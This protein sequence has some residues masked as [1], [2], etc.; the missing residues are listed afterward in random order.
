MMPEGS[1]EIVLVHIRCGSVLHT[2]GWIAEFLAHRGHCDQE[3]ALVTC[4]AC[5]RVD[6]EEAFKI[7]LSGRMELS[8]AGRWRL[9]LAEGDGDTALDNGS[10]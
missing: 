7:R 1:D 10:F 5:G 9:A 8:S 2:R 4:G 3:E 6:V